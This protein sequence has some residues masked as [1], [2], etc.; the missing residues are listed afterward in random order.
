MVIN[1]LRK[2]TTDGEL[3]STAK[4]LIRS[5]KKM[6]DSKWFKMPFVSAFYCVEGTEL[7]VTP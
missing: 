2:K 1:E 6:L 4:T 3:A 7:M 5:W